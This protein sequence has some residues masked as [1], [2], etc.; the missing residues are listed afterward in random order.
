QAHLGFINTLTELSYEKKLPRLVEAEP[1]Q[2]MH[3]FGLTDEA[4]SLEQDE[5]ANQAIF[6]IKNSHG[7]HA[8]PGAMLVA[9]A[10]KYDASI[11]VRNLDGDQKFVNA[12][13]L[14]KVIAMGVKHGHRLEFVADGEDANVALEG[15]GQAIESGLGEG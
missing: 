12:K 10:K 9:S 2:L 1:H 3:L 15:I 7:L 11:R 14:M 5:A 6:K 8:R 13:S 4:P